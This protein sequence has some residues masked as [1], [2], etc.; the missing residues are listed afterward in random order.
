MEIFSVSLYTCFDEKRK[1]FP[2]M[3]RKHLLKFFWFRF[4]KDEERLDVLRSTNLIWLKHHPFVP[5]PYKIRRGRGCFRLMSKDSQEL[6]SNMDTGFP[7]AK[8]ND[9]TFKCLWKVLFVVNVNFNDPQHYVIHVRNDFQILWRHYKSVSM[10]TKVF[11]VGRSTSQQ[12]PSL[13][14]RENWDSEC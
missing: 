7:F 3:N 12:N 9:G 2:E 4:H 13:I 8:Y 14:F 6:P 11:R 5:G 10:L 1:K